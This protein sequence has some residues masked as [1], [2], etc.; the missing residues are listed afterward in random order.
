MM[1]P[2]GTGT[3]GNVAGTA[4]STTFIGGVIKKGEL[5]PKEDQIGWN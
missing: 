5:V 3:A 2:A 1:L 4:G